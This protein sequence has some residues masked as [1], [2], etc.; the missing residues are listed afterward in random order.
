MS[1]NRMLPIQM[2]RRPQCDEELTPVRPWPAV[3]HGKGTLVAVFERGYDFVFEF[4]AVDA[5]A[6][7]TGAGGV[8]AL[9]HE[10]ADNTVEDNVVVFAGAGEFGEVFARLRDVVSMHGHCVMMHRSA[11]DGKPLV[12]G[13]CRVQ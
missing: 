3:C 12:F 11:D 6:A 5:A 13:P 10:T 2:R 1:K 4:A 9:D 7:A 8:A